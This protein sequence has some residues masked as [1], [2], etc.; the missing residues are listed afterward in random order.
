MYGLDDLAVSQ[1]NSSAGTVI[2]AS[3]P[4]R[5]SAAFTMSPSSSNFLPHLLGSFQFQQ[6]MRG[7][8]SGHRALSQLMLRQAFSDF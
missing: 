5:H 3:S 4:G 8:F 6:K 2:A 7:E 1:R